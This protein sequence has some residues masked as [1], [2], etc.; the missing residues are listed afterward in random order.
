VIFRK[1]DNH[2]RNVVII[3]NTYLNKD[4]NIDE[5]FKKG[6]SDKENHSGIGLWKVKQ[7]INKSQNLNLITKKNDK[8]FNQ[9]LEIYDEIKSLS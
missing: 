4:V 5:I 9:K 2:N 8:F 7:Y 3:E 6:F 1:E